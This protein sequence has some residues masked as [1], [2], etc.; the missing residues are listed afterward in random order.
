MIKLLELLVNPL[1]TL[2]L[3][4]FLNN[5]QLKVG[6]FLLVIYYMS[7]TVFVFLLNIFHIESTIRII[8]AVIGIPLL[9]Y[10]S[11]D[12]SILKNISMTCLY[13][14]I[15]GVSE[16][17][18][19]GL[20]MLLS[21]NYELNNFLDTTNEI[22]GTILA[23]MLAFILLIICK[24]VQVNNNYNKEDAFLIFVPLILGVCVVVFFVY[25]MFN[26]RNDNEEYANILVTVPLI[27]MMETMF[28][29][30]LIEHYL[31]SKRKM[32]EYEKMKYIKESESKYY[33]AKR[34]SE[35]EVRKIYHDLKN[36]K[37]Y[38]ENKDLL[39][40]HELETL[41]KPL[42]KYE[43]FI[44]TNNDILNTLLNEK[45]KLAEERGIIVNCLIDFTYGNFLEPLDICAIFGNLLDNAIEYYDN[46]NTENDKYIEIK[47]NTVNE[48]LVIKISNYIYGTIEME[49][50][51]PIS[52]KKDKSMHGI[53]LLSVKESVEK[54]GGYF[55]ISINDTEYI[56]TIFFP[57][58]VTS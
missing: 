33:D 16:L 50:G 37:I 28:N 19:I 52:N 1:E 47:I 14:I 12:I 54:Y 53:G 34:E 49:N 58:N 21:Q 4:Y 22:Y 55:E 42:K 44:E 23:K 8:C 25:T 38:L 17:F 2:Y 15:L 45:I 35:L 46:A 39:A 48:A 13:L 9:F 51:R 6:K 10:L 36:Y 43:T 30:L 56:A 20:F 5:N 29:F 18:S 7:Y 40:N 11:Y 57:I 26:F 41:L 3:Y 31:S 32:N 27:V 24:K